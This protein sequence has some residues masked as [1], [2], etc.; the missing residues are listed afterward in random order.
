MIYSIIGSGAIGSALA[1]QFVKAGVSV[2]VANTRGPSSIQPLADKLGASI[3]PSQLADA[4]K[5]DVVILAVPFAST[6]DI[7]SQEEHWDG[8]VVV[9]ATNAI[10]FPSFTPT[11]LGGKPSTAVVAESAPGASVVK[12]F[13]HLGA[14]ILARDAD[15]GRRYVAR[16]LF[17]SGDQ[18]QAK[19][20]VKSLMKKMGFAVIDVGSLAVGSLLHQFG[21]PLATHSLIMQEQDFTL[22]TGPDLVER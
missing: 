18:E 13:N 5:A 3:V 1:K 7:L 9:D 2:L 19:E 16:T 21:G 8:R 15:D 11:D 10:D 20:V 14:N 17:I 12:G 22:A 4:L 6:K